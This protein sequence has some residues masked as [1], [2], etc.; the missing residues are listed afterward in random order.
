MEKTGKVTAVQANGSWDGAYGTMYKFEVT[1]DNGDTGEYNSKSKEQEKFVIGK[2]VTYT[3]SGG[4]F[5]KIKPVYAPQA[6]TGGFTPRA[7]DPKRQ[8]LIIKQSCLKAAVDTVKSDDY[9][10]VLEVATIY[11]NWVM[12]VKE[13]K[14]YSAKKENT[15]HRH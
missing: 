6:P 5:P 4:K 7:E 10:A 13:Q 1:F 8:E 3:F 12:G 11:V 2:E 9:T 14:Y 15:S